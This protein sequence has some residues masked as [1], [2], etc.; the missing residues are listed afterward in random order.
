[1]KGLALVSDSS[2]PDPSG[3]FQVPVGLHPERQQILDA[4]SLQPF[5]QGNSRFEPTQSARIIAGLRSQQGNRR[6]TNPE[7]FQPVDQQFMMTQSQILPNMNQSHLVTPAFSLD[8]KTNADLR[9]AVHQPGQSQVQAPSGPQSPVDSRRAAFPVEQQTALGLLPPFSIAPQQQAGPS[10]A[11]PVQGY[12]GQPWLPSPS[13]AS[14]AQLAQNPP[15][16]SGQ[17]TV[18]STAL[19]GKP[20]GVA[21]MA[22][23]V[24]TGVSAP[25][26]ASPLL[27]LSQLGDASNSTS[28][29]PRTSPTSARRISGPSR[30]RPQLTAINTN[31]Q[32]GGGGISPTAVSEQQQQ[33]QQRSGQTSGDRESEPAAIAQIGVLLDEVVSLASNARELFRK[34]NHGPSSMCL[35]E[36]SR[37]LNKIGELGTQSLAQIQQGQQPLQNA[38]GNVLQSHGQPQASH[39]QQQSTSG[40]SGSTSQEHSLSDLAASSGLSSVQLPPESP[41]I[42]KRPPNPKDELPIKTMRGQQGV[43]IDPPAAPPSAPPAT[44]I[45]HGGVPNGTFNFEPPKSAPPPMTHTNS[46]P[47]VPQLKSLGPSTLGPNSAQVQSQGWH[48]PGAGTSSHTG[49]SAPPQAGPMMSSRQAPLHSSAT[50]VPGSAAVAMPP[51]SLPTSPQTHLT[52]VRTRSLLDEAFIASQQGGHGLINGSPN[53]GGLIEDDE[54]HLQ[55]DS[56]AQ[57]PEETWSPSHDLEDPIGALAHKAPI[58]PE[59]QQ[60]ISGDIKAAQVMSLK[61][62]IDAPDMPGRGPIPPLAT[63]IQERLDALFYRFLRYVCSNIDCADSNGEG[64]HQTLMPKRMSRLNHSEDFRPFKFRIQAFVNRWQEEVYK[65]GISEEQCSPKRLRQYLWTQP[66]ISRFNEDGRKAKSKGN[67]VWIVEG[68]KLSDEE[69]EFQRFERKIVGPSDKVAQPGTPW[70]W[71][72]RVWDPQMSATS[73][74][75]TFSVLSK[76]IWLDFNDS[77]DSVEKSLSGTPEDGSPGGLVSV[78]AQCLHANGTLQNLEISFE[79][80]VASSGTSDGRVMM[81]ADRQEVATSHKR[82]ESTGSSFPHMP[83]SRGLTGGPHVNGQ[84]N[85]PLLPIASQ[86]LGGP[87][88]NASGATSSIPPQSMMSFAPQGPTP[89]TSTGVTMP[90]APQDASQFFASMNYPFT[91]PDAFTSQP[92]MFF[93]DGNGDSPMPLAEEA[94]APLDRAPVQTHGQHQSTVPVNAGAASAAAEAAA[95][96]S[97]ALRSLEEQVASFTQQPLN[98]APVPATATPM[99]PHDQVQRA[100]VRAMIERMQREQTAS[101]S[102]KLPS[103]RRKSSV[104]SLEVDSSAE[105][106]LSTQ[107]Q[108]IQQAHVELQQQQ[109][110][111]AF[112]QAVPMP[113][114]GQPIALPTMHVPATQNQQGMGPTA[115]SKSGSATATPISVSQNFGLP[116]SAAASIGLNYTSGDPMLSPAVEIDPFAELNFATP[117]QKE[118]RLHQQQPAPQ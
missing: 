116:T 22:P 69:W 105:R 12:P 54:S 96:S 74:K 75:P 46:A 91:P 3:S 13:S 36:L 23:Y 34:G 115:S 52:H 6:I 109:H 21:S 48:D 81:S 63:N 64:I 65:S 57:T 85:M 33:Q 39:H 49:I 61:G 77:E 43:P 84:F 73:I 19:D 66:Y 89:L 79:L 108:R 104:T 106:D 103:E 102:L 55:G 56:G 2:Q 112:A 47:L 62:A 45:D 20:H 111:Q 110:A 38:N 98:S 60:N 1:M 16:S 113:P 88:L 78:S 40:L 99:E 82:L 114:P 17:Q 41:G 5:G 29:S 92:A 8:A 28:R 35:T 11:P 26:S 27:A 31:T 72:L 95:A 37:S 44:S 83:S 15:S 94:S 51:H 100:Q 90:P 30:A 59:S 71:L 93:T 14:H 32:H 24:F 70:I 97:A 7:G 86:P 68:R 58:A 25:I 18:S 117:S 53:L 4:S 118:Q 80:T 9:P 50:S 76:P 87:M 67:H 107:Q 101:L 10:S 42:R